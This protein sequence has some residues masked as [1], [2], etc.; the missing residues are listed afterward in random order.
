MD[1][2]YFY[3]GG[4]FQPGQKTSAH[5]TNQRR[6]KGKVFDKSREI[7]LVLI[8]SYN[9]ITKNFLPCGKEKFIGKYKDNGYLQLI[10]RRLTSYL[11]WGSCGLIFSFVHLLVVIFCLSFVYWCTTLKREHRT[12]ETDLLL[13]P[14]TSTSDQGR[15]SPYNIKTISSREV[16]RIQKNVN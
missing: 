12:P 5:L 8:G 9:N 2:C 11:F 13:N 1:E 10:L 15:I 14:L 7:V 3:P 16:M 6:G 4:E